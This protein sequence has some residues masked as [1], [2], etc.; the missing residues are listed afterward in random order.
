MLGRTRSKKTRA[1]LLIMLVL[2]TAQ[3]GIVVVCIT[4]LQ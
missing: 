1:L 4:L 3:Q 2:S